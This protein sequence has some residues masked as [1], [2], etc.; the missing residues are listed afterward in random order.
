MTL[1]SVL[2]LTL[3][4]SILLSVFALGLRDTFSDAIYLFRRPG[5]LVRALLSMNVLMPLAALVIVFA[6][7]LNP[8]VEVANNFPNQKLALP[9]VI[10]YLILSGLISIPYLSWTKR[11]SATAEIAKTE[12]G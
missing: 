11:G 1:V 12:A 4:I 6:F 5:E 8:A 2:L 3:K 7:D 9:A 10:I